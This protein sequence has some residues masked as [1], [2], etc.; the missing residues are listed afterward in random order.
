MEKREETTHTRENI[1]NHYTRNSRYPYDIF[2]RQS[3]DRSAF[4]MEK[5]E[6]FTHVPITINRDYIQK[7]L[8]RYDHTIRPTDK[9]ST[10]IIQASKLAVDKL[11]ERK[12]CTYQEIS[13]V[14]E[15]QYTSV[16]MF[17]PSATYLDFKKQLLRT[18]F[19]KVG[20]CTTIDRMILTIETSKDETTS[21]EL[22][23]IE[24]KFNTHIL[25]GS[26]LVSNLLVRYYQSVDPMP[27]P[28]RN[29]K[30]REQVNR[31]NGNIYSIFEF[32]WNIP[33]NSR[34]DSKNKSFTFQ[35]RQNFNGRD[36][37]TSEKRDDLLLKSQETPVDKVI[38]ANALKSLI[39]TENFSRYLYNDMRQKFKYYL[40]EKPVIVVEASEIRRL[41]DPHFMEKSDNV[42]G[43]CLRDIRYFQSIMDHL[44]DPVM[45]IR[46]SDGTRKKRNTFTFRLDT[47]ET[48]DTTEPKNIFSC[49][50]VTCRICEV[51]LSNDVLAYVNDFY[52]DMFI[53]NK[54]ITNIYMKRHKRKVDG[55]DK[56][57][58]DLVFTFT[59]LEQTDNDISDI[60]NAIESVEI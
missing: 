56:F 7:G 28:F 52:N 54:G 18:T 24:F 55:I 40:E 23:G 58:V 25:C 60:S 6:V 15:Y 57:G 33:S 59:P 41:V 16:P 45:D 1:D 51:L 50:L 19:R 34:N 49:N 22:H 53:F 11:M 37:D 5:K 29:L 44:R 2:R 31:E 46:E 27:Q 20:E 30:R 43:F 10:L 12:V 48:K 3:T 14:S 38:L 39:V 8:C 35:H 26:A 21:I 32:I 36:N 13:D 47:S 4:A 17:L 9:L 42:S